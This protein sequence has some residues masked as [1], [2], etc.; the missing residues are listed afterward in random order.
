MERGIV[1]IDQRRPELLLSQRTGVR[2]VRGPEKRE[3]LLGVVVGN[4]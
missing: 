3:E 2:R 1:A 4:G